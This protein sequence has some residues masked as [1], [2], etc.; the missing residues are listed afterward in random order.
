MTSLETLK[1]AIAHHVDALTDD[2]WQVAR[3]IHANPELASRRRR[4]R[5]G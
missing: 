4:P 3:D 1:T 2:L 5:P